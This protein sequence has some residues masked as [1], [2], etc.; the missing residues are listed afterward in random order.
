MELAVGAGHQAGQGAHRQAVLQ[1]RHPAVAGQRPDLALLAQLERQPIPVRHRRGAGG[2]GPDLPLCPGGLQRR[3]QARQRQLLGDGQGR[4]LQL[5]RPRQI[6][7]RRPGAQPAGQLPLRPRQRRPPAQALEIGHRRLQ[8]L[9][10]AL[11][12][13]QQEGQ[14]TQHLVVGAVAGRAGQ[15]DD[16]QP[17]GQRQHRLVQRPGAFAILDRHQRLAQLTHAARFVVAEHE[18]ARR[19]AA[20]PR[21]RPVR[22]AAAGVRRRQHAVDELLGHPHARPGGQ[23]LRLLQ[24]LVVEL[25]RAAHDVPVQQQRGCDGP[26]PSSA[27]VAAASAA[28]R[29][30]SAKRPSN[31]ASAARSSGKPQCCR[32]WGSSPPQALAGGDARLGHRQLAP[33]Q[34]IDDQPLV[35]PQRPDAVAARAG[36]ALGL[37]VDGQALVGGHIVHQ[38]RHRVVQHLHDR[39]RDRP[40]RAPGRSPPGPG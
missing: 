17:A 16:P 30:A 14:T 8:V 12:L 21:P 32:S 11:G 19:D 29:S 4:R 26:A 2:G 10:A 18:R 6:V 9:E 39:A 13:P 25:G 33:L 38:R 34:V 22:V 7:R 23:Q 36:Q 1:P 27:A 31:A 15:A 28:R 35:R 40:A 24:R 20:Q 5:R 37:Q 3:P